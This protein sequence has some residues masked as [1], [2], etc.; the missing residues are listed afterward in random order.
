MCEKL[1]DL[2]PRHLFQIPVQA[3][4][5]GKIIARETIRAL[6]DTQLAARME[7]SSTA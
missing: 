2:I 4:I 7:T 3:A 6:I 1:K 5:G